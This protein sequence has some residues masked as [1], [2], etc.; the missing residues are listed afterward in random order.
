VSL[1]GCLRGV[2]EHRDPHNSH[3][4]T[5]LPPCLLC[6]RYVLPSCCADL[7]RLSSYSEALLAHPAVAASMAPPEGSKDYFEGLVETYKEYVARRKAAAN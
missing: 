1:V 2:Q 5:V 6:T 3:S 7:P 4:Q